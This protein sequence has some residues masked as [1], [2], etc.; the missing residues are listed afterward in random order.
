M[1][2]KFSRTPVRRRV[3][4]AMLSAAAV[5]GAV[6]VANSLAFFISSDFAEGSF[7]KIAL[8]FAPATLCA[9]VLFAIAAWFGAFSRW[10]FALAAGVVVGVLAALLG[11]TISVALSG[12][13]FSGDIFG[14]AHIFQFDI[15]HDTFGLNGTAIGRE[16]TRGGELDGGVVAQRYDGLHRAFAEGAFTKDDGALVILQG[17]GDDFRG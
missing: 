13:T 6:I 15:R 16:I 4:A 11:T 7:G 14:D 17:A 8:Y 9:F 3:A 2:T 12:A 5:V 10:Y 1:N